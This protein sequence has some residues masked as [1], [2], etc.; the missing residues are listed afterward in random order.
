[1]DK[2]RAISSS[3]AFSL[4]HCRFSRIVPEN[5]VAFAAP[6]RSGSEAAQR[7]FLYVYAI[8]EHSALSSLIKSRDQVDQ[9]RFSRTCSADDADGFSP[10]DLELDI[11]QEY[12][13]EPA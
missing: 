3:V 8:H 7:I 4:R 12:S 11:L 9:S 10:A 6:G 1:M 2:A 13:S 5:R